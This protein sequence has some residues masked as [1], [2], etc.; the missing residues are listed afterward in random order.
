MCPGKFGQKFII[1]SNV[2]ENRN[3]YFRK[4]SQLFCKVKK[5]NTRLKGKN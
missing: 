4:F 3:I 2:N 5:I 1:V